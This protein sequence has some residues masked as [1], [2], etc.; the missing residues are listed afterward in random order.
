RSVFHSGLAIHKRGWTPKGASALRN[1]AKRLFSSS[2]WVSAG[3]RAFTVCKKP[4]I[5]WRVWT[6][7]L[8]ARSFRC[9]RRLKRRATAAS[10]KPRKASH[11]VSARHSTISDS[12]EAFHLTV[13]VFRVERF[14]EIP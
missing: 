6:P 1:S 4:T 9:D 14:G 3:G 7:R 12:Q 13:E 2:S 11:N 5:V 8:R 10:A